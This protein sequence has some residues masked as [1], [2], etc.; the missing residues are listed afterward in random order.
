M[1]IL[2]YLALCSRVHSRSETSLASFP[3]SASSHG[4][5]LPSPF[6]LL[7]PKGSSRRSLISKLLSLCCI[8]GRSLRAAGSIHQ[9]CL[10]QGREFIQ[11]F[12]MSHFNCR[13]ILFVS[14]SSCFIPSCLCLTDFFLIDRCYSINF[15]GPEHVCL[16]SFS[17]C[18]IIPFIRILTYCFVGCLF[19]MSSGG[20]VFRLVLDGRALSLELPS[21][22]TSSCAVPS[23]WSL[24][25]DRKSVV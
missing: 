11:S 6:S 21:V 20:G 7:L 17:A 16:K 12:V 19:V 13:Q 8:L 15:E 18:S 2:L 5:Q 25:A 4:V 22:H 9:Q 14:D 1:F 10:Q 3:G 23:T 24:E